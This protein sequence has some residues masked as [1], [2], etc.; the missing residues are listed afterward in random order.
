MSDVLGEAL[1]RQA[2]AW[3]STRGGPRIPWDPDVA[4]EIYVGEPDAD[5]WVG[6]RPIRKAGGPTLAQLA[7]DLGPFH[8]SIERY[9]AS[10]WFLALEGAFE[11]R[12]LT[13]QPNRPGLDP[14]AYLEQVRAY[15]SGRGRPARRLPIGFDDQSSLLVVV[16]NLS[17]E[18]SVEDWETGEL[19]W[20]AASL[21]D[22]LQ[23]L[24]WRA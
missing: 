18:V 4:P 9:F 14:E 7:P 5:E 22:V 16:D 2:A 13:L 17:G 6:W 1:A 15:A 3:R 21:D 24:R 19:E 8:P 23:R 11:G 10:W 20:I 12:M